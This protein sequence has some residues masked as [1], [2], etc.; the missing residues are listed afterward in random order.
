MEPGSPEVTVSQICQTGY[1]LYFGGSIESSY[2]KS[3]DGKMKITNLMRSIPIV[4][5]VFAFGI[6]AQAGMV[7]TA[8]LQESLVVQESPDKN[9]QRA[10]IEAQ[11]LQGGVG[12]VDATARVAAMTDAEISRIYQRID[13]APAGGLDFILIGL[14]VFA[15]LEIT[16]YIDVIPEK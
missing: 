6:P 8:Q 2:H 3:G 14:V 13:E 7:T 10:W 15:V 5:G 12:Q 4:L 9:G 1:G 11:L 16:G